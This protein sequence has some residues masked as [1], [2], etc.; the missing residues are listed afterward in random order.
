MGITSEMTTTTLDMKY[1][2][3]QNILRELKSVAVAFSAGVDS[4]FVLKAAVDTLGVDR[5]VAVTGRSASIASAELAQAEVLARRFNVEHVILDTDELDNPDYATN[6]DNRCYHC[7][8]T[9]FGH[10]HR[11]AQDRGIDA[12]VTGTNADDL[13]DYRPGLQAADEFGVR[14]PAAEVGLTKEDIRELSLRWRL[15]THDKPA[16]PCL[17][18]RVPYGEPITREKLLMIEN[19]EAFLR[20]SIGLRTCRVR[21]HGNIARIEVSPEDFATLVEPQVATRIDQRFRDI[22]FTYTT[23]DLAG[24]RSGRL[25]EMIPLES[26]AARTPPK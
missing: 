17:S 15:D 14:A 5:V 9:L 25:N 11:F 23:L 4:T 12:I 16:S 8:T 26:L 21:H 22:G 18:S 2:R 6:P 13:S 10:M 1:E 7:K 20:E 24:F 19:A 3:M